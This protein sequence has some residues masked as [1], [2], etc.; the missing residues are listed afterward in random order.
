MQE[1]DAVKITFCTLVST[2]NC[3]GVETSDKKGY[4]IVNFYYETLEELL[5]NKTIKWPVKIKTIGE[6]TAVISDP[7]IPDDCYRT[8][9]CEV[10]CPSDLLPLQQKLRREREIAR[11]D[12]V[13]CDGFETRKIFSLTRKLKGKW[14]VEQSKDLKA[15][16]NKKAEKELLMGFKGKT[17]LDKGYIYAPYIP[18]MCKVVKGKKKFKDQWAEA[19]ASR[20]RKV[21]KEKRK[22]KK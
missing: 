3:F 18:V 17:K 1:K 14:T 5:K 12:L 9:F 8:E 6:H 21:V 7:R 19:M 13:V 22:G 11:G 2:N 4:R 20:N 16:H 15:C 10:C